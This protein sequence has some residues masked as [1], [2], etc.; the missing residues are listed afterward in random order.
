MNVD[1][2]SFMLDAATKFW[3][4]LHI[5]G[6]FH[7]PKEHLTSVLIED[8]LIVFQSADLS[9]PHGGVAELGENKGF[10]LHCILEDN[11]FPWDAK[12]TF[13]TDRGRTFTCKLFDL[14]NEER[15]NPT[16]ALT[17]RFLDLIA[18]SKGASILDVGGR[19]RSRIDRK[20]VFRDNEVIV[21]DI[22]SGPN[23]DVVADA[24]SLSRHFAPE[25]FEFVTSVSVFEHLAMPWKVAIELNAI[26][27][28]GG[29]ALIHSHQTLGIHDAPWDFW[30]FS[31]EAWRA[32]FN[33][34]T[35]FEII[36]VAMGHPQFILPFLWRPDKENA[37]RSAGFESS[38]ALVR[39]VGPATESWKTDLTS[40]V[41]HSYPTAPDNNPE[42]DQLMI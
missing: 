32:I 14:I 6:W 39:K 20:A 38:L 5:A 40:V 27:K 17:Q 28:T 22:L 36:D 37:E 2:C 30:R 8:R 11:I 33:S 31:D 4:G 16:R 10:A 21:V 29:Y 15:S 35:G 18:R 34:N 3:R 9:L 42:T 1:G 24:H 13:A 12:L 7:H 26:M 23:V 25:T 41:K 19:Q